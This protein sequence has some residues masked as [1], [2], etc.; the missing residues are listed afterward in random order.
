MTTNNSNARI[1]G[2]DYRKEYKDLQSRLDSLQA[3]ITARLLELCRQHP[4]ADVVDGVKAG[5][6]GDKSYLRGI[7][8]IVQITCIE[9]IESWLEDQSSIKQGKLFNE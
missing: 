3:K 9:N 2:N 5:E 1:T 6:I 4:D 7:E 8:T